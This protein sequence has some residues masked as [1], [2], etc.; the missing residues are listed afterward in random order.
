[1]QGRWNF[2]ILSTTKL[3]FQSPKSRITQQWIMS[4][5][6]PLPWWSRSICP[7]L[8]PTPRTWE[9]GLRCA[10]LASCSIHS[11]C[12]SCLLIPFPGLVFHPVSSI[13]RNVALVKQ[14][15]KSIA[16]IDLAVSQKYSCIWGV[17]KTLKQLQTGIPF[18]VTKETILS[19][20]PPPQASWLWLHSTF[21]IPGEF[22]FYAYL[23][24]GMSISCQMSKQPLSTCPQPQEESR[25][26]HLVEIFTSLPSKRT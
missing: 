11:H 1:M 19:S 2:L 23:I 12:G 5:R 21:D 8:C 9:L 14:P 26:T 18:F 22:P 13:P 7:A 4:G 20:S 10:L 6:G 3:R 16:G 25:T 24:S 17:A 15:T